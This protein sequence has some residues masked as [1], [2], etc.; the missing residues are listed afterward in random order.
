MLDSD[1]TATRWSPDGKRLVVGEKNGRIT[2]F[3]LV[4][5]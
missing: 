1:I 3:E 2:I 4:P 5:R